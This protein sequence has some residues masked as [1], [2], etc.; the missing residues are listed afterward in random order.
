MK[1][2]Y[3]LLKRILGPR[4]PPILKVAEALTMHSFEVEGI[5]GDRL[6][7]NLPANR[8]S[9]AASHNGVA[10]EI[11]AIFGLHLRTKPIKAAHQIANRG[12]LEVEI[13]DKRLCPRYMASYLSI[14][15][16]KASPRWM[17]EIL[18]SSGIKPINIVVDI[19]NYVM[20]EIGEPMHAF[21]AD[22]L[23]SNS[24]RVANRTIIVRRAK[25]GEKLKTLDGQTFRFEPHVLLVADRKQALAI[26]GIKGGASSGVAQKTK[27][28]IVEAASF[29]APA[30]FKNARALGLLTDAAERFGHE[31]HP[32]LASLGM[33]R[34]VSL[35]KELAKADLLDSVDIYPKRR[36]TGVIGFSLK[37]FADF[38]G[39]T[40]DEKRVREYLTFLGFK[41]MDRHKSSGGDFLLVPPSLRLDIQNFEDVAEEV[42]RLYGYE[43]IKPLPPVVS[44]ATAEIAKDSRYKRLARQILIGLGFSEI[45]TTSFAPKGEVEVQNPIASDKKYLRS[46]LH[47]NLRKSLV[48]NLK[49]FDEAAVFEIGKVFKH[50][51]KST[52]NKRDLLVAENWSI[53]MAKGV[54]KGLPFYEMKGA[55]E[56]LLQKLGI[57]EYVFLDKRHSLEILVDTKPIGLMGVEELLKQGSCA[58]ADLDFSALM[59]FIDEERAY[60]PPP[61]FPAVQRDVSLLLD[62]GTKAGD[63][64]QAIED[65][66][67]RYVEDADVIDY[68]EDKSLGVNKKSL[69]L[70]IVFRA[71]DRTLTDEEVDEEMKKIIATLRDNEFH[72]Q[73][74]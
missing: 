39:V 19:M 46:S 56:L 38:S 64:L 37:K 66:S 32:E 67:P 2:S 28:I 63:I 47:S 50:S 44:L 68:F 40:L 22:K 69:T 35:L 25:P 18:V 58:Y 16:V 3:T 5:A 33:Q 11:S 43:R 1:F 27:N 20:L 7:I 65:I 30:I 10:R 54:K 26:A 8:Y 72:A 45:Y 51:V 71:E 12:L 21:D 73:V 31:L 70:R 53:V 6:D 41:I 14:P 60:L 57:T 17:Q 48:E 13:K 4:T 24:S 23:D 29:D 34:A 52:S 49:H 59:K 62:L 36:K 74:R 9:D 61:K 55:V 15:E 42:A